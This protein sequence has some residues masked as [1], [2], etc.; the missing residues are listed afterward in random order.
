MKSV[1]ENASLKDEL[2]GVQAELAQEQETVEALRA[3]LSKCKEE[4]AGLSGEVE[5]LK[6]QLKEHDKKSK[7]MWRLQ[8]AQSQA[9]CVPAEGDRAPERSSAQCKEVPDQ[10]N[11]VVTAPVISPPSPSV[12]GEPT[13][14]PPWVVQLASSVTTPATP[15]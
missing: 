4:S 12:F 5:Q 2:S 8:C 1:L 7:H 3:E 6:L 11:S 13:C 14:S 9:N 10:D 15:A